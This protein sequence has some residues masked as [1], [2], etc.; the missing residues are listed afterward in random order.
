MMKSIDMDELDNKKKKY[1]TPRIMIEMD[2]EVRAG[3]VPLGSP[4]G[5][6]PLDP[7]GL[8]NDSNP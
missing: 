4:L 5:V 8:D 1:E 6:D 2:L 7:L 3:S